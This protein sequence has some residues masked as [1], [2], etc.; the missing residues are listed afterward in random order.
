M[1]GP[2]VPC[3]SPRNCHATPGVF[4]R[5]LMFNPVRA[6]DVSQKIKTVD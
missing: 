4:N 1:N 2:N 6:D 5:Q 3:G